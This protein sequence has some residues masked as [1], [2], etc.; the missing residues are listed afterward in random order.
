[1]D[2]PMEPH[3]RV[4]IARAVFV[5]GLIVLILSLLAAIYVLASMPSLPA[6]LQGF[7]AQPWM[8][9]LFAVF[10]GVAFFFLMTVI[11]QGLS[12]EV[13]QLCDV[14]RDPPCLVKGEHLGDVGRSSSLA[15]INIRQGLA[16]VVQDLEAAFYAL[17]RP[18]CG[19]AAGHHSSVT[20]TVSSSRV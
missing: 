5:C 16:R 9:A 13:R 17:N 8:F 4:W 2:S 19:E 12:E 11:S 1:M 18:G 7:A 20:G 3:H 10:F 6:D 15:G 14:R